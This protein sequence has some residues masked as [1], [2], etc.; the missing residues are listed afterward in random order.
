[1]NAVVVG[2]LAERSHLHTGIHQSWQSDRTWEVWDILAGSRDG[3]EETVGSRACF[4]TGAG[5][6]LGDG[7]LK[8]R[9]G[10]GSESWAASI[11]REGEV[12]GVVR[13]SRRRHTM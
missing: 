2:V 6:T 12:R 3:R 5:S 1:M 13:G 9:E 11:C 8:G 7:W 4:G 10:S